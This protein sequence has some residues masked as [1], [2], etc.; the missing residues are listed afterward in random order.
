[1]AQAFVFFEKLIIRSHVSKSNRKQ[2]AGAC[3]LLSAKLNDIKGSDLKLLIEVICWNCF[4]FI[5]SRLI[6]FFLSTQKIESCFR[7][8]HKDLL[9]TEFGVLVALEFN[10]LVPIWEVQP[11]YL[12]LVYES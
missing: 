2:I 7:V 6:S 5:F 3:I 4:G 1:M 11:H 8:S 9:A 12:R 10:L